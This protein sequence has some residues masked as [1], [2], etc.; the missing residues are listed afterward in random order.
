MTAQ[1]LTGL[2][3]LASDPDADAATAQEAATARHVIRLVGMQFGGSLAALAAGSLNGWDCIKWDCINQFLEEGAI[4]AVGA[5]QAD[6]ERDAVAVI[7]RFAARRNDDFMISIGV[8][9][10]Q[11]GLE[12]HMHQSSL[13]CHA[14]ALPAMEILEFVGHRFRPR[15]QI[16]S[17]IRQD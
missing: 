16:R 10:R 3:A 6:R 11:R 13:L 5:G 4:M 2:D 9:R 8:H 12:P 7:P 1:P 14:V 17:C 15:S